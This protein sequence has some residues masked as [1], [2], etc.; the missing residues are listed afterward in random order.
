MISFNNGVANIEQTPGIA[1]NT[2]ALQPAATIVPVGTIYIQTD[3]GKIQR[4]N[5]TTWIDLGGGSGT[6][7]GI[8]SVLGV[9]QLLTNNRSINTN[10][11]VFSINSGADAMLQLNYD[12]QILGNLNTSYIRV[13]Q[14]TYQFLTGY[15]NVNRGIV[16]DFFNKSYQLGEEG[17]HLIIDANFG[18]L[19]TKISGYKQGLE[20]FTGYTYKLGDYDGKFNGTLI[21]VNDNATTIEMTAGTLFQVNTDEINL[22]GG[23]TVGGTHTP[24]GQHL[25]ISVNGTQ[26]TI[27]LYTP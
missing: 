16:I 4:S 19:N 9:A 15:N 10:G 21:N 26:Y 6:T 23:L 11:F 1:A 24:T 2:A 5:G 13:K 8:D 20:F 25:K 7:P 14:D 12:Y 18:T 3:G 17:S 22:V 27:N